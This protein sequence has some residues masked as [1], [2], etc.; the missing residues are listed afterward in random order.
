[1]GVSKAARSQKSLL[2]ASAEW[3]TIAVIVAVYGLTILTVMRREVLTPWLT[4]PFLSVLGAWHLSMQHETIHG[5]PFRRQWINDVIG[6]IP[7][8]LWIPYISYKKD[9]LEHHRSDLTHPGLDNESYYVSPE[10]WARAGKIRRAAYWANRTILFRMFVWTIVSTVT[11]LWFIIR[12]MLRGEKQAW[13]AMAVHA[14]GLVVVAYLVRSVGGM[15]LWQFALGTTYGGRILNAIRPF[16]EHKYQ[17]G[18]ETRTAM[19]MAGPFMS[20]LMLNNNLHVA[21][22]EQPGVAWYEVPSLS[23]RVNAVER[24]REVGLLYEGG[25]AEVFRKFSLKPMGA[26]LRDSA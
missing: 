5:H 10:A 21:H 20:L 16:P 14:A 15:P 24:A 7:V 1:V 18:S 8:T 26:P 25:Y 9:H 4:I 13:F 12:Q 3:R 2:N 19:V 17:D 23:G 22:H 11:Y 6:S